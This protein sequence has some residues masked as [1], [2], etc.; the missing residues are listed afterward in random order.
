MGKLLHAAITVL[1]LAASPALAA[2]MAVKAPPPVANPAVN[3]SG[4]YLGVNVGGGIATGEF[5]DPCFTCADVEA[6]SRFFT[7][8][9]QLGYNWQRGALVYGV[10][11]NFN[12]SSAGETP[13]F[14]AFLSDTFKMS[15]FGSVQ[16]RLGLAYDSA[17]FYVS[18]G[19]ATAHF[20]SAAFSAPDNATDKVWLPGIALGTGVEY[21]LTN[22]VSVRGELLYLLFKDS[23]A[24]FVTP[25]GLPAA[26]GPN[27]SCSVN[28]TYS[29][30]L[31]RLGL[32]W[33]LG[34]D[35]GSYAGTSGASA[36]SMPF[37]APH[38]AAIPAGWSGFYAGVNAGGGV[39]S[40]QFLDP[41]M[42]CGDTK[43]SEP[44]FTAGGQ[45]GYNWQRGALVYGLEGDLN[46][47][48]ANKTLPD[49]QGNFG[50]VGAVCTATLKMDAFTS[51]RGRMGMA[52]DSALVYV[53]AGPAIAHFNSAVRLTTPVAPVAALTSTDET[54]IPGIAA[55]T[56][57][58]YMLTNTMSVRGEIL[59]LLFEDSNQLYITN[60]TGSPRT[61]GS[62][63][64]CG[65]NFT[66]S[67]A[68]ARLGLDWKLGADP[69][70]PAYK[71][72]VQGPVRVA[73]NWS[74]FYA[75]LNAGGGIAA[76]RFLDPC[77]TCAN[78]QINDPSFVG[79]GQLGYN[80]QHDGL[81]Y[82]L[83]G[84]LNWLSADKTL[85]FA[86]SD[87]GCASVCT[88]TFKMDAFGSARARMGLAYDSALVYVTGGLAVGHF[89][90]SVHS[91]NFGG[92]GTVTS[93]DNVWL[94]G[95]ATG[96]GAEYMLT[97]TMSV[98][99]EI[100][101]LAF[102]DSTA[103]YTGHPLGINYTYSAEIARL[104]VNWKL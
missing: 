51:V 95:V 6:S 82:G 45:L 66:Y 11:G 37:K 19:V 70:G 21:M 31:V 68:I 61:C 28:F 59:Y 88:A 71:A 26:C 63:T 15:A 72:P 102:K 4:F 25:A 34:T 101:Y 8:G 75:G 39:A 1:V 58:E 84:D 103:N 99:G 30:A 18:A 55:G 79:G 48:S 13:P 16:G 40:G 36:P 87:A 91:V 78:I 3:W 2:D 90:S 57:V 89:N 64:T 69:G 65:I 7:A 74:G 85:P 62:G 100:L 5:L 76:G 73:T 52:Y 42:S 12:W 96:A 104:G 24:T 46:W 49:A 80:W 54:W 20:H 97:N 47:I 10:E 29:A 14:G 41:C 17:L 56:G 22:N 94:P 32:D 81:V 93:T 83:E 43:I 67:A 33:K 23:N 60:A 27:P 38:P 77:F 92:A 35:P 9:G 86:Q 53:T 44:S 98:R 50:C